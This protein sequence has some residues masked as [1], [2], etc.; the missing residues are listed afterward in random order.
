MISDDEFP[1]LQIYV[2]MEPFPCN[3]VAAHPV[4]DNLSQGEVRAALAGYV[5]G[6]ENSG[7]GTYVKP[8]YAS[9]VNRYE[10]YKKVLEE[11]VN[12]NHSLTSEFDS[13]IFA[14]IASKDCNP[15]QL[16]K[17]DW[18]LSFF[19]NMYKIERNMDG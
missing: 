10:L 15:K 13:V 12:R 17:L 14:F 3:K 2:Q 9:Q 19:F 7:I 18:T 8:F 4:G 16:S 6:M 1:N 5:F 11:I